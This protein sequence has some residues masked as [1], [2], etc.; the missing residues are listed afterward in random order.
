M[1]KK[2][3]TA[4]AEPQPEDEVGMLDLSGMSTVKPDE[5]MQFNL[6]A[7]AAR[8][9]VPNQWTDRMKVPIGR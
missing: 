4:K 2:K 6:D 7:G 9:A 8:T 1:T 3:D 5:W